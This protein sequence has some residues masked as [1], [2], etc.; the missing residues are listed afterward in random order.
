MVDCGESVPRVTSA[1]RPEPQGRLS[2]RLLCAAPGHFLLGRVCHTDAVKGLSL[3]THPVGAKEEGRGWFCSSLGLAWF[4]L[5]MQKQRLILMVPSAIRGDL[6]PQSYI[7]YLVC[8]NQKAE[9]CRGKC[10]TRAHLSWG[11]RSPFAD[12]FG[13][14]FPWVSASTQLLTTSTCFIIRI[15]HANLPIP[16]QLPTLLPHNPRSRLNAFLDACKM[17][18]W[19]QAFINVC[20]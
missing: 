9:G 2:A 13:I 1:C 17:Q 18:A 15:I 16:V 3:P 11:Q 20:V 14:A 5:Q 4:R 7:Q 10:N 19:V 8:E 12:V 6:K